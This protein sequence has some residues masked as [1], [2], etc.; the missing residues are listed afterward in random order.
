M[1][2]PYHHPKLMESG[3]DVGVLEHVRRLF[4]FRSMLGLA[5]RLSQSLTG[6]LR[7]D[8]ATMPPAFGMRGGI[9]ATDRQ[10]LFEAGPFEIE[11]HMCAEASGWNLSG[12]V[13][14]PTDAVSGEVRLIGMPASTRSMLSEL[15]EFNLLA[16]PAGAYRLE[17][18]LDPGALLHIDSLAVGAS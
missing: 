7:F 13:L 5:P 12:Q 8:S 18:R 1:T 17:L 10:L 6:A 2:A 3:N 16:V 9:T 15:L 4:R 11:L 14:G